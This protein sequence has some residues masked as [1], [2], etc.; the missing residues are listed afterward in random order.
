MLNADYNKIREELILE[1]VQL[2]AENKSPLFIKD[3]LQTYLDRS[4]TIKQL[5]AENKK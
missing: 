2:I 1:G 3:K 4:Y 5:K